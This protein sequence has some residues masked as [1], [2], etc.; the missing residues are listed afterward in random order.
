MA[1]N[2]KIQVNGSGANFGNVVQGDGNN[3]GVSVS[4]V[5]IEKGFALLW[6]VVRRE[7]ALHNE[8]EERLGQLETRL[9]DLNATAAQQNGGD[10][11]PAHS[12]LTGL[13]ENFDW[14]YPL[15]KDAA[16]KFLPWLVNSL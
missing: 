13:K 9:R 5:E 6:E 8:S 4:N 1:G 11:K 7:A 15:L 3:V 16:E 14:I 2:I 10:T 12:I